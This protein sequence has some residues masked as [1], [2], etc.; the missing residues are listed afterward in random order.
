[1]RLQES[2]MRLN[3]THATIRDLIHTDLSLERRTHSHEPISLPA[4]VWTAKS[5]NTDIVRFEWL[6]LPAALIS[7]PVILSWRVE[8]TSLPFTIDV[9]AFPCTGTTICLKGFLDSYPFIRAR[10]L[11]L[12]CSI[13][14]TLL[15][16]NTFC[17][18]TERLRMVTV[19]Q[20]VVFQQVEW[21]GS[22]TVD[23]VR[24]RALT[25]PI[26]AAPRYCKGLL[27]R[28]S[29]DV[30]RIV[31]MLN[32]L[33]RWDYA[34]PWIDNIGIRLSKDVLYL[35]F[36]DTYP[37]NEADETHLA[38]TLAMHRFEQISLEVDMSDGV[39][40]VYGLFLNSMTID[41]RG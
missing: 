10:S 13:S 18:A 34:V 16:R 25:I 14:A 19:S 39:V 20:P 40:G 4:N 9:T 32:G 12:R 36:D 22:I 7:T 1:M 24:T 27:L 35:P 8:V 11:W 17:G 37:W 29:C 23:D 2:I 41:G 31:L 3:T 33:P 15:V 30:Q 21:L 6:E 5:D 28:S 38:S 26:P